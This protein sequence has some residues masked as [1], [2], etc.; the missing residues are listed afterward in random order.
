MVARLDTLNSFP[1]SLEPIHDSIFDFDSSKIDQIIDKIDEVGSIISKDPIFI[2]IP[3][4]VVVGRNRIIFRRDYN[5]IGG[6]PKPILIFG[7]KGNENGQFN[8]PYGIAT[9]SEGEILV[10]DQD[11]HRIQIFSKDGQHLRQF[12]SKGNEDG[13]FNQPRDVSIDP[14][15]DQIIVV[16]TWNHRIQIFDSQG[17]F[18]RKFG[19]KGIEDGQFQYPSAIVIDSVGNYF[20]SDCKND[21]IQIFDEN[22][23]FIRKFGSEGKENGKLEGPFGLGLLSNGNLVIGELLNNRISI[24]DNQ[25]KKYYILS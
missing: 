20:I 23:T 2:P 3:I 8:Y 12:G 6:N 1:L 19:S 13:Q 14:R 11:N 9:N 18:I 7:S 22:G 17:H 4:P 10:C 21:R 5:Q 15:N 25:E 24:F 16:D